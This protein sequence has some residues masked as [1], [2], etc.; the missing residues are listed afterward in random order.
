VFAIG[1]K[2]WRVNAGGSGLRRIPVADGASASAPEFAPHDGPLAYIEDHRYVVIIADP[3][4][5][6]LTEVNRLDLFD[7]S[8]LT[9]TGADNWDVGPFAV[10]WSPVGRL[11]LTTR[12]RVSGSGYTDVLLMKPDGT[13]RRT[14]LSAEQLVSSFPEATWEFHHP[15]VDLFMDAVVIIGGADGITNQAYG[16]NGATWQ[17]FPPKTTR[18]AVAVR[19]DPFSGDQ[20]VTTSLGSPEP[21]GPIE[22]YEVSGASEIIG[23]GCGATWSPDGDWIAY[24]DGYGIAVQSL[25]AASPDD[26]IYAARNVDIGLGADQQPAS[27]C[28]GLAVT[29]RDEPFTATTP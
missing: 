1:G 27:A 2:L 11:L 17:G 3:A 5:D 6:Q 8:P 23:G 26:H 14:F 19:G 9:P 20:L 13:D 18:I 10:H 4:A 15:N 22:L 25:D 28:D 24:Y 16:L 29:W 7:K 12:R 21:F